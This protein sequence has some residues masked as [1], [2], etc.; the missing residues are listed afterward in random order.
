MEETDQAA[1]YH[2]INF[3]KREI[4]EM[5]ELISA[6]DAI[7]TSMLIDYETGRSLELDAIC[8]AVIRRCKLLEKPA[9][10]TESISSALR[11]K[12]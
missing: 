5:F 6:F 2:N 12:C 8:G 10:S 9:I 3:S 1:S 11:L 7:K 4:D